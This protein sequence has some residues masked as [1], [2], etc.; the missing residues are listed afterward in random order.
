M[1]PVCWCEL[2]GKALDHNLPADLSMGVLWTIN[3]ISLR[4]KYELELQEKQLLL[5]KYT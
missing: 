1:V 2:A 3:D 4:K 5:K